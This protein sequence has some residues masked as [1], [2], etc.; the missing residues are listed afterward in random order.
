M[1]AAQ[2]QKIFL[3]NRVQNTTKNLPIIFSQELGQLNLFFL[4]LRQLIGLT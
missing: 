3:F 2:Q 1:Q 4:V